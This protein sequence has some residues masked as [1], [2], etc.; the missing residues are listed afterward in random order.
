[1][2][3]GKLQKKDAEA[4]LAPAKVR[5]EIWGRGRIGKLR[6]PVRS[7]PQ[8]GL[9][10]KVFETRPQLLLF[11]PYILKSGFLGGEILGRL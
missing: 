9:G 7:E 4:E 2:L 8:G 6:G 11:F 1:M 3:V 10:G 5:V